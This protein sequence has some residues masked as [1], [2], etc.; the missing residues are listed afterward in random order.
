MSIALLSEAYAD[1]APFRTRLIA[2]LQEQN[3]LHSE[4]IASA[5]L[6]VPREA[7]VPS[8][9]HTDAH[10]LSASTPWSTI[11]AT[12]DDYL[13]Q[14]YQDQ[15]LV[16]HLDAHGIPDSSSSM[17]TVMVQMLET[18]D[19]KSNHTVL[20]IGTGTGYNAALTACLARTNLCDHR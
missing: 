11:D 17:P 6:M 3:V 8:F 16:T 19:I 9:L 18:L 20:E 5:L 15:S 10:T 7:F 12:H 1:S 2:H 13:S 4:S 14:M